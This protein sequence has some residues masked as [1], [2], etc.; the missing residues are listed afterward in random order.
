MMYRHV[1]LTLMVLSAML[2]LCVPQ[3]HPSLWDFR[4]GLRGE[5]S[6]RF[7]LKMVLFCYKFSS[8]FLS[9]ALGL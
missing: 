9:A 2:V 1:W 8:R 5:F 4:R 7:I 3:N 6:S